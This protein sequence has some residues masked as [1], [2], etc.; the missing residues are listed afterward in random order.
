MATSKSSQL[1]EPPYLSYRELQNELRSDRVPV[2]FCPDA[3]Q[4]LF[5]PLDG[6][7]PTSISV[8][9]TP[10]SPDSLEPYFL[11][12]TTGSGSGSGTWHELSQLPLTEPKI[13]SVEVSVDYLKHWQDT[14][15]EHHREHTGGNA[16]YVLYGDMSDDDRPYPT[17]MKEDGGWESDSE[18][19]FL[20]RCC[21]DDRPLKKNAKLLVKPSAGNDFVTVHDYVSGKSGL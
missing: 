20:M 17:E 21:D 10:R 5:W 6:V 16:E 14:W 3:K 13:S 2:I 12:D 11:P 19:E 9:K 15:L 7:F 8:M 1:D 18:T 4:R